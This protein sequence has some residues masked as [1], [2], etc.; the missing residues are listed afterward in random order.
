M[1]KD[2]ENPIAER[3]F[4]ASEEIMETVISLPSDDTGVDLP[5]DEF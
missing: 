1:K 4:P 3:L 2:Y 5:P